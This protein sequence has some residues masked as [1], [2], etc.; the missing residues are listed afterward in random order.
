MVWTREKQQPDTTWR[1]EREAPRK[2]AS[3]GINEWES[4]LSGAADALTLGWGDEIL[5][6]LAAA[7]D[8]IGLSGLWGGMTGD[9]V[10]E[11]S[12]M[13]QQDAM[14]ANPLAY[15]VGQVAGAFAG[16]GVAGGL[17]RLALR[18]SGAAA[19]GLANVGAKAGLGTRIA[20]AAFK[21]NR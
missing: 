5:G 1:R 13:Q 11:W 3:K 17:G 21:G 18:G 19:T 9:Q 14:R 20:A 7:G 4:G 10:G 12:R 2:P 8:T 16:G 6:G 15:G